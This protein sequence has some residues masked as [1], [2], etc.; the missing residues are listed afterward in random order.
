M[1]PPPGIPPS[2]PG[3]HTGKYLLQHQRTNVTK[4]LAKELDYESLLQAIVRYDESLRDCQTL[5][6]SA[7]PQLWHR[8]KDTN[9]VN[10]ITEEVSVDKVRPGHGRGLVLA[11]EM[12]T[13][14]SLTVLAVIESTLIAVDDWFNI[15]LPRG[16]VDVPIIRLPLGWNE[17]QIILESSFS[18]DRP[19]KKPRIQTEDTCSAPKLAQSEGCM[20]KP[21]ATVKVCP[22][23]IKIEFSSYIITT[24][25]KT[26]PVNPSM[27]LTSY[28]ALIDSWNSTGPLHQLAFY[29]VVLD[30]GHR[31][32]NH[33][34]K[35]FRAIKSLQYRH[36][37][38]VTG[39][40]IQNRLTEMNSYLQLLD[41]PSSLTELATYIGVCVRPALDKDKP[42]S[43]ALRQIG[44]IFTTRHYKRDS[45]EMILPFK[46]VHV[47]Y[48]PEN[49]ATPDYPVTYDEEIME[50]HSSSQKKG[51]DMDTTARER[52]LAKLSFNG[53][54]RFKTKY[55]PLTSSKSSKIQRLRHFAQ[56][57]GLEFG[58]VVL[59]ARRVMLSMGYRVLELK[60]SLKC[61]ERG[62]LI[63]RFHEI[64]DGQVCL[65][66]SIRVGGEGLSMIGANACVFLDLMWNPS[67]HEQAM[68]RLHRPGQTKPVHIYMPITQ[69]SYEV[70]IRSA[71]MLKKSFVNMVYV[72]DP[73]GDLSPS[74][75][76]VEYLEWIQRMMDTHEEDKSDISAES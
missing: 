27:I 14:K 26:I 44:Q 21:R 60:A 19:A 34:S 8:V 25:K 2:N 61:P 46:H 9:W 68:D 10:V 11:D 49:Q 48:L 23:S 69:L 18:E 28:E 63:E 12:G 51:E 58:K 1:M 71:Q 50:P 76:P 33:N 6:L 7:I 38:V 3:N 20:P 56:G 40:P 43:S 42:D 66:S 41:V 16:N 5:E 22:K 73:P 37:H 52:W 29:R 54:L 24:R 31:A 62:K 64:K 39:T 13:G 57:E 17:S 74:D 75:I 45:T 65:L 30:E 15:P 72:E 47:F 53:K 59:L 32:K 4:I 70:G 67:W 36:L 35:T 55:E